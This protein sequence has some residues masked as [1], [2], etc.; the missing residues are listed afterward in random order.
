LTG[1]G[2]LYGASLDDVWWGGRGG[3]KSWANIDP[4]GIAAGGDSMGNATGSK[5]SKK[6]GGETERVGGTIED[7]EY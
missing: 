5:V 4:S 6:R 2:G 3:R 1:G 7:S